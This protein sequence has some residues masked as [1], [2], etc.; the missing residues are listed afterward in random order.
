VFG[1]KFRPGGFRPFADRR[2]S[3]LTDR[4]QVAATQAFLRSRS[5]EPDP[6]ALL[7]N[8]VTDALVGSPGVGETPARW[9]ASLAR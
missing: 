8:A 3:M 6:R 7:V 4:L 5:I 1:I 2:V 9:A